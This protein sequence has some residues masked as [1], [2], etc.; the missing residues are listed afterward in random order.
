MRFSGLAMGAIALAAAAFVT[1]GGSAMAAPGG[2]LSAIKSIATS[3]TMVEKT[4]GWHRTCRRGLSDVHRHIKGVGRA[5][6]SSRRC[7]KNRFGVRRCT[8]S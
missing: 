5:T 1:F 3:Q 7:W 2:S 8:W 6:C 4:H